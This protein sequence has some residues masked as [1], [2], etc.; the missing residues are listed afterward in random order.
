VSTL[1]E[2]SYNKKPKR[3]GKEENMEKKIRAKYYKRLTFV[4]QF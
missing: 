3:K 1:A 2:P 4:S